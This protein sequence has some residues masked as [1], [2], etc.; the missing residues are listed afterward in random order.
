MIAADLLRYNLGHFPTPLEEAPRLASALGLRQLWIKRDDCTGFALGG[1]K[2]RQLE[3]LLGD[4]IHRQNAESLVAC[5]GV[6]SNFTRLV[7]AAGS[8]LGLPVVLL[9]H[10]QDSKHRTGNLFLDS[11]FGAQ[12]RFLDELDA[13]HYVKGAMQIVHEMR[14][15]GRSA[16]VLPFGGSSPLGAV[17]YFLAAYELVDQ[18]VA[19]GAMI[20][21]ICLPVGSG[22]TLA[23][24]WLAT[25]Q[26]LPATRIIGVSV[27]PSAED[28]LIRCK[29]LAHGITRLLHLPP[30]VGDPPEIVDAWVGT[31][32][33]RTTDG[34]VGVARLAA[35]TEGLLIDP[36]YTG[37]ALNALQDMILQRR[38]RADSNVLFW[39]TGGM[40]SMFTTD[41]NRE[42]NS[43]ANERDPLGTRR[44]D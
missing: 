32:Y 38:V 3:F 6:Q 35:H 18:L 36:I 4:A 30:P 12:L 19:R 28:M 20:D 24:I 25:Q 37:K 23:G 43:A 7:A 29:R 8:R 15:Q 1:S 22:G 40:A 5:G 39:H 14:A 16:V 41:V 27:G 17:G 2:V 26:I 34:A 31:G 11:W 42:L 44:S 9:L 10:G 13:A 33:G 21:T